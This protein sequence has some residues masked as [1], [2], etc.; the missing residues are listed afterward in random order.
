MDWRIVRIVKNKKVEWRVEVF[1]Q[2]IKMK[3]QQRAI[4]IGIQ[5]EAWTKGKEN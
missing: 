2:E 1:G 5:V 3:V 4:W